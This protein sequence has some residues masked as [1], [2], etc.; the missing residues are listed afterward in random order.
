MAPGPWT[1]SWTGAS[2]LASGSIFQTRRMKARP[3][4]W[5]AMRPLRRARSVSS[6]AWAEGPIIDRWMIW[7]S[8]SRA[9][10][11]RPTNPFDSV[12]KLHQPER[13]PAG[14]AGDKGT[15]LTIGREGDRH[16]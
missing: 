9:G 2:R 12:G 4:G 14:C 13:L 7:R 6:R 10:P 3:I 16:G 5:A 8:F 15:H 1:G 11:T